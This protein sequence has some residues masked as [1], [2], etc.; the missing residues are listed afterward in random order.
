MPKNVLKASCH[1]TAARCRNDHERPGGLAV[2]VPTRRLT[3]DIRRR[4]DG[5]LM[6]T[7]R[8]L[9]ALIVAADEPSLLR[10]LA[11]LIESVERYAASL[12]EP[13]RAA[14]LESLSPRPADDAET[15]QVRVPIGA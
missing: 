5:R 2:P 14:F 15:W 13:A 3:L 12:D 9:P 6:A 11:D 4:E 7:C 8:E 10:K 1:L